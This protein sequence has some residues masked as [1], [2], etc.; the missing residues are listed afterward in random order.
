MNP[1]NFNF[2]R[3]L[4]GAYK[5]L[6]IA[7]QIIPLY[8]QV[9]PMIKNAKSAFSVLS[10]LNKNNKTNKNVKPLLNKN[11][12]TKKN[13]IQKKELFLNNPTFFV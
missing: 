11:I 13:T 2:S 8:Q 6:N 1:S 3:I 10:E 12:A 7:N 4:G 5:T 9:S